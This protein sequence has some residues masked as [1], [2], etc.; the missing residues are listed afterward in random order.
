MYNLHYRAAFNW[1]I[2]QYIIIIRDA[3]NQWKR[4]K[5]DGKKILEAI[6]FLKGLLNNKKVCPRK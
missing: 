5:T 4:I 1:I 3:G 6:G 2:M